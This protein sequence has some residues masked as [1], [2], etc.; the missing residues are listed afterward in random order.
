VKIEC[1]LNWSGWP[2]LNRRPLRPEA[3]RA[4][5]PTTT[6]T[7]SDLPRSVRA[8]PLA[9]AGVCGGCY[10][11]LLT[12]DNAQQRAI[13]HD[14]SVRSDRPDRR[15]PAVVSGGRY[16]PQVLR[17]HCRQGLRNG[18]DRFVEA[19]LGLGTQALPAVVHASGWV[20]LSSCILL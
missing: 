14:G 13:S 1:L 9:S 5:S 12:G 6:P 4:R 15:N 2:D 7:L 18:A 11:Q 20:S 3:Q 19:L 17:T 16:L 10:C 8:C